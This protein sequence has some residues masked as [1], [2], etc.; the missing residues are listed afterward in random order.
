MRIVGIILLAVAVFFVLR[1]PTGDPISFQS[2]S[3]S[4]V[5]AARTS[6]VPLVIKTTASW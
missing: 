1:I 2:Y 4:V 6:G 3:D 5:V